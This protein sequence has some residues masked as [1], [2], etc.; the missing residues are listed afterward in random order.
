MGNL[1]PGMRV[2]I[3]EDV[4]TTAASTLSAI[5]AAQEAKL[6]VVQVLCLV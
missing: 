2:A 4:V 6:D 1:A 3:V 5:E